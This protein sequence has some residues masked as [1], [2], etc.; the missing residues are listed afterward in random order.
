MLISHLNRFI[1]TKTIKTAG[2]SVESYFEPFCMAPGEWTKSHGRDEYVSETGIIG[3]RGSHDHSTWFAH[4]Q[5]RAIR[6]LIGKQIWNSYFKFTVVRNPFDKLI[7]G[8]YMY[9]RPKNNSERI[10]SAKSINL[11]TGDTEIERFRSW[12]R[13]GGSII[14]RNKYLIADQICVDYFIRFEKLAEGVEHVCKHLSLPYNPEGI[15][16]FK[17]GLR[18][19]EKKISDYYDEAT[20]KTVRDLYAWEFEKFGYTMPE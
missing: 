19:H 3:A 13:E 1:F 15:P 9:D 8:F 4:M 2:T 20:E 12:I 6:N 14:D 5:A 11:I 17:S 7:S 16:Q 18:P 10:R